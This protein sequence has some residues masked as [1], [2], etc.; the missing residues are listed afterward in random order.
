VLI[1]GQSFNEVRE[2]LFVLLTFLA[3]LLPFS[4]WVF[5]RAVRRAK[6]EGSL[7]QY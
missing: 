4:V 3:V 5:S 7:I 2:P 6:R 1:Q